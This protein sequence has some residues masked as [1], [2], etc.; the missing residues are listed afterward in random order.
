M[1]QVSIGI[2]ALNE[3]ANIARCL[4]SA[5]DA[6]Q[7]LDGEVI[8]ADSGSTDRTIAIAQEFPV[9]IVQ[10][11]RAQD[12]GCGAGAQLAFQH[13]RGDYFYLLD[14]DMMIDPQFLSV[15]IAY[16]QA[17]PDVAGVGGWVTEKNISGQEFQVRADKARAFEGEVDHLYCG[18]LYRSDAIRSAGH[19]SDRNLHAF[20]EFELG[21]RLL[22]GGW[23]LVRL[24]TPGVDHFGHTED[25]YK[26]LW[27]RMRSGYAGGLGEVVRAAWMKPHFSVVLARLRPF[28]MALVVLGWWAA[29]LACLATLSFG[30]LAVLLAIPI[31]FLVWRRKSLRLGLYS[32]A[33]CNMLTVGLLSGLSRK[34]VSPATPLPSK[35]LR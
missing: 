28:Q 16:L 32:F 34:R 31:L 26:L 11:S 25:G 19:F 4:T 5:L 3:E 22:A 20:E 1:T 14:G 33:V 13:A 17:H 10:L 8:L 24:D 21:A 35:E 30:A 7:S 12:R 15:G 27:R 2:K 6:L 18:G 29:L 9:R 23:K